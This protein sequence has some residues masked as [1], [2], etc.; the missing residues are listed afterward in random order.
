MWH[1][2][3]EQVR[4]DGIG[5]L[6]LRACRSATHGKHP[7]HHGSPLR[8]GSH[9]RRPRLRCHGCAW[10]PHRSR[11][12]Q[13]RSRPRRAGRRRQPGRATARGRRGP[14]A[15]ARCVRG[16][17]RARR[18]GG[19]ARLA[20]AQRA[21]RPPWWRRGWRALGRGN[22]DAR[23]RKGG[24][25]AIDAGAGAGTC[26]NNYSASRTGDAGAGRARASQSR[27]G[28]GLCRASARAGSSRSARGAHR[29]H[30]RQL[31]DTLELSA[32]RRPLL[33]AAAFRHAA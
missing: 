14:A 11:L 18:T 27:E 22:E 20:P 15:S 33:H 26:T 17:G 4:R 29:P 10:A 6:V 16:G 28:A 23:G 31:L 9:P 24:G 13:R 21:V 5:R 3:A 25:P 2:G 12:P 8:R 19:R 7:A 32:A 1:D 30:T